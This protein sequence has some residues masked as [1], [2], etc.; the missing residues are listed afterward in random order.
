MVAGIGLGCAAGGSVF[1]KIHVKQRPVLYLALEDGHRRLQSRFRHLMYGDS[2]PAG[3]YLVTKA[4]PA[5][6]VPMIAEFIGMH[7]GAKPLVI[8]DT[9]GK[10]KPPKSAGQESYSADY[11]IGS[12]LKGVIDSAPGASLIA[13]HHTRKAE[14]SDF[15][16]AVSGT[17]G[18]AGSADFILVL[19]RRRKDTSAVLAVTGR[20]VQENEYAL[21]MDDGRWL[22]DG[23]DLMDAA[24]TVDRRRESDGLGERSSEVVDYVNRHRSVKT[25]A[26]AA[27]FD[28]DNKAASNLLNRLHKAGRIGK[29][30]RGVFTANGESGES[31]ESDE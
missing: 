3:I 16:D 20:D 21:T 18:I 27:Q 11:A 9:L 13:V 10:V 8:L 24:A 30:D 12:K 2:I 7:P 19:T 1:S 17:Q 6:V 4:Q 25:A 14:S 28:M 5:Q 23:M 31:G 29:G 15:I 26:V 22:L